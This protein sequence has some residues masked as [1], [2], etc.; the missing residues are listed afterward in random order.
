MVN[1]PEMDVGQDPAEGQSRF[2]WRDRAL[3]QRRAKARGN[4]WFPDMAVDRIP[5]VKGK[6]EFGQPFH[7]ELTRYKNQ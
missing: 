7:L 5:A 3:S 6:L 4:R 1:L 2:D